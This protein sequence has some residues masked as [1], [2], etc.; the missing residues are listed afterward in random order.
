MPAEVNEEMSDVDSLMGQTRSGFLNNHVAKVMVISNRIRHNYSRI[1]DRVGVNTGLLI[2]QA[3]EEEQFRSIVGDGKRITGAL[4][5][6]K[7]MKYAVIELQKENSLLAE[8]PDSLQGL[9]NAL[10]GMLFDLFR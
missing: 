6:I 3:L 5:G 4:D 1:L 8:C 10:A 7:A 9:H 2:M